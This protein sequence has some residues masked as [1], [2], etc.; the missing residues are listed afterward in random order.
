[1]TCNIFYYHLHA[2]RI[3]TAKFVSTKYIQLSLHRDAERD[4]NKGAWLESQPP[5][6]EIRP[7]FRKTISVLVSRPK[8]IR[9]D[10]P[11]QLMTLMYLG[12]NYRSLLFRQR[13]S[14]RADIEQEMYLFLFPFH[15][16]LDHKA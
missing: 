13:L 15:G 8:N 12:E 11:C 16:V 2:I 4:L 3:S 14:S 1:M 9:Q 7:S 6:I 5:K 10:R